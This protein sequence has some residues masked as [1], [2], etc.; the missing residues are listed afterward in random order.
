MTRTILKVAFAFPNEY[1]C[2]YPVGKGDCRIVACAALPDGPGSTCQA[3]FGHGSDKLRR[4]EEMDTISVPDELSGFAGPMEAMLAALLPSGHGP[5]EKLY[6][7]M[8]H[9]LLG[10]GKYLRPYI[11][12]ASAG[13]FG[14]PAAR[15][16]RVGAAV[17]MIHAFSLVHDDLPALDDDDLRRGKPSCHRAFGE[18]TAILAGDGLHSLAFEVLAG[19]DTH[20]DAGV[21]AELVAALAA[22]TGPRGM[23]G[24]QMIDLESEHAAVGPD[25]ATKLARLKTGALFTVS[26]SAGAILGQ[27]QPDARAALEMF[28]SEF[29]LAF[30]I[31]DDLL[32]VEGDESALGKKV[33]KDTVAGKATFVSILGTEGARREMQRVADSAFANLEMFGE[34]ARPLRAVAEY[35]LRRDR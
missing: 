31:V 5:E 16:R 21:R 27:A 29:G 4:T 8:S 35:A 20:P 7:A 30:Q 6:A 2:L 19:P 3:T 33:G 26:A 15:R 13:M 34:R 25:V 28:G 22:A 1:L 11:V 24:G 23:I 32:D 14:V 12:E 17:E 10:G 9:A 18:A